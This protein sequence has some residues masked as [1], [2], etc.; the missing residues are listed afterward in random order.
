MNRTDPL[1]HLSLQGIRTVRDLQI[2]LQK[3]FETSEHQN[4]VLVKLYQ[5]LFPEW[6]KIKRLEGFPMVGQALWDYICNLFIEFD[7]IHH[8]GS[9][10]GGVWINQ[11][12]SASAKLDPWQISLEHCKVIYS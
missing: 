4:S 2:H 6:N 10:N 9:F 5:M 3:I 7:R 1:C 12:F 11:G 8:P